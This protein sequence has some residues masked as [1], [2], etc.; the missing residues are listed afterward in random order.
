MRRALLLLSV[1]VL[2]SGCGGMIRATS[3]VPNS[4]DK[5]SRDTEPFRQ[6]R[7]KPS[8]PSTATD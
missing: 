6:G 4:L 7:D 5:L 8:S 1:T 3:V 2:L